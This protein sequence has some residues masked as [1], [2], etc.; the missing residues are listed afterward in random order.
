MSLFKFKHF[1]IQ[2]DKAAMKVG[3]DGVLLGA[4][5]S[6]DNHVNSILD[7]GTGTG[8][9]AL[10]LA[11][12]SQA[13]TV[14]ALEIEPKAFEQA[15]NNFEMSDWGDRLYCYHSSLQEFSSEIEDTYDLI[16][17]NPP[18]FKD[19]LNI[20]NTAR[21]LARQKID[22]NYEDLLTHTAK[23]LSKRGQCAFIIPFSEENLFLEIAL[24]NGLHPLRK[25]HVKGHKLAS[26]KRSLLQLS[27]V[28]TQTVISELIIEI[29]RHNYT[30]DYKNLVS[31]FYLKM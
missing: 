31:D 4:W 17:S 8:L 10:Q 19:T 25:T 9:I 24:Q 29:S 30:E 22:L 20:S 18:F 16:V 15:V 6:I 27:F 14:D 12:R 3:T 23:L 2:Q 13:E 26:T 28:K 7:I 11:Q 21:S 5:I 1:S